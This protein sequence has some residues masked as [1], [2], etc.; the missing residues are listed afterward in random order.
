MQVFRKKMRVLIDI[1]YPKWTSPNRVVD[2][3]DHIYY[4]QNLLDRMENNIS[5]YHVTVSGY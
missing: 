5:S 3:V 1:L 4:R 2:K